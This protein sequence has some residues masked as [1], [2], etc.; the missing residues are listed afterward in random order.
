[1]KNLRFVLIILA[2]VLVNSTYLSSETEFFKLEDEEFSQAVIPLSF[3]EGMPIVEVKVQGKTLKIFMD[4]GAD[5]A[6]IKIRPDAAKDL[7]V[8]Y[9]DTEKTSLDVFGEANKERDFIIPALQIG[10]LKLTSFV[11][12]EELRDL[13]DGVDGTMG[14]DFLKQFYVLIDYKK[15]QLALY[16]KKDYPK[17]LNLK[18]WKQINFEHSNIGIILSA[19][20]EAFERELRF[21]LDS[22]CVTSLSGKKFGLLYSNFLPE[23][24]DKNNSFLTYDHVLIDD[25]LDLGRTVF[26]VVDFKEPPIDGFLGD[27]FFSKY[28]VFIDFD[29][30]TLFVKEF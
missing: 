7:N 4:T 28:R 30:E 16:P 2:L 11:A 14:N 5:R 23:L 13:P 10:K 29:A 15:A 24:A 22:G 9:L 21:C 12:G 18:K 1:M 26:W 20:I 25:E 27:V 6:T 8:E 17:N 19:K 3:I